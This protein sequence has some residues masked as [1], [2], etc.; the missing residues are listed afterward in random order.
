MLGH[1]HALII[2]KSIVRRSMLGHF[3]CVT[4]HV[5]IN[6]HVMAAHTKNMNVIKQVLL[7]H[8]EGES[9]RSIARAL[10]LSKNTVNRYISIA[11]GDEMSMDR[12]VVMDDV[13]LDFRFNGGAPAYT[14]GRYKD[15][16]GRLAYLQEQMRHKHM[17]LQLLWEEYRRE[18]PGGYS[19]SQFRYHY[20]Q[21]TVSLKPTTVLKDLHQG[22]DM[23]YL[24]YAGDTIPIVDRDSGEEIKVQV[25]V[26]VLPAS[27][28][29]FAMAVPSQRTE[30]FCYAVDC[31]LQALGG[32]PRQLVPDN[33]KAAVIKADRY[34]P[35]INQAFLQLANHYGC[36][37]NP[38][39]ALHPKDKAL[40]ENAVKL[41]YRRVYAP[42]RKRVFH[43]IDSLNIAIAEL[44][45]AHNARRIQTAEYSRQERFAAVDL[46]NLRPLPP[47]RFELTYK[48]Q[49]KVA[50]NGC[51]QL[52]CDRHYYS[53]PY[54]FIGRNTT[55]CF[56]RSIVKVFIDGV[57]V[58]T[59]PRNT[60]KGGYTTVKEHLASHCNAYRE[61]SPQY[62]IDRAGGIS[63]VFKRLMELLFASDAAPERYYRS[64]D[65]LLSLQRST[66][67]DIFE[68]ACLAAIERNRINYP[69][70]QN[71]IK[72]LTL[73]P[74][75]VSI[76]HTMPDHCNIRGA[77]E[78]K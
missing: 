76:Q 69:Y 34:N 14:D 73:T 38:A 11:K 75:P 37:V 63:H 70:M 59:H 29:A 57:C 61:R 1:S 50:L 21:N 77:S 35:S 5:E 64:A 62:Y 6:L 60:T 17:T 39:R 33:L 9:N 56:S 71:L 32:V 55:V 27:D 74:E 7:R 72:A 18:V 41:I 52:G 44:V 22:G 20:R 53:V 26:A 10:S 8:M 15:L 46:P 47:T 42:L 51:V 48:V 30:D 19:L 54:Q 67:S 3:G 43:D 4:L 45:A 12:L 78:Y 2:C 58:S 23:L 13:E 28:Y 68:T 66:D 31:C 16:M 36:V 25:F 65:G 24:D 49:V 40:V